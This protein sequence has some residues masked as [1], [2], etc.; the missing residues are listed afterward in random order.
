M[1]I[2]DTESGIGGSS[3]EFVSDLSTVLYCMRIV[4]LSGSGEYLSTREVRC[5][6]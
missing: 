2:V 3:E 4:Y 5:W 1:Q 6:R